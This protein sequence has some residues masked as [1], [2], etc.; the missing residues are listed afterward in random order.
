MEYPNLE[1]VCVYLDLM[2]I[3]F[4]PIQALLSLFVMFSKDSWVNIMYD[5]LD[6]VEVD[7]QVCLRI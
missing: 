4:F 6:A 3:S 2:V 5:G 1:N 7:K